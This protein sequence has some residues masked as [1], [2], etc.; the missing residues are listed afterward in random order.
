MTQDVWYCLLCGEEQK[1]DSEE[2][3]RCGANSE[4]LHPGEAASE[5][6]SGS[7]ESVLSF[8]L[9][10]QN[11]FI[12]L[13]VGIVFLAFFLQRNSPAVCII[14]ALLVMG[15]SFLHLFASFL[16]QRTVKL[17]EKYHSDQE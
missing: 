7:S 8:K 10:N 12:L 4:G 13:V 17:R 11:A 15:Y 5:V 6:E 2:C 3:W 14:V 16:H 1:Q 9:S